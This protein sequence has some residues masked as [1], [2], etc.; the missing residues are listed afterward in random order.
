MR[1]VPEPSAKR[2]RRAPASLWHWDCYTFSTCISLNSSSPPV[3]LHAT[4]LPPIV[5]LVQWKAHLAAAR[6]SPP[7]QRNE[8]GLL[9][10]RWLTCWRAADAVLLLLKLPW[11]HIRPSS[12]AGCKLISL[13]PDENGRTVWG[14][15]RGRKPRRA[16]GLP[17]CF[18]A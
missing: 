4:T 18:R 2:Y 13:Q 17:K 10:G 9:P 8:E 11:I 6:K 1:A 15:R 14:E 12:P 5:A 3:G 7:D 16:Y